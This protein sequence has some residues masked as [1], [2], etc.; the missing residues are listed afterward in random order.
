MKPMTSWNDGNL[1]AGAN[2]HIAVRSRDH[3][4]L[5]APQLKP[6]PSNLAPQLAA[7]VTS[8]E[9]M[10]SSASVNWLWTANAVAHTA[11]SSRE[12]AVSNS[13]VE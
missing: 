13:K 3:I 12:A 1:T 7:F 2:A 9:S 4:N 8:M 6:S 11:P 10:F 5:I